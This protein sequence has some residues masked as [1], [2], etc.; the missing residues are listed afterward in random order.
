[1][2]PLLF[3]PLLFCACLP[4]GTGNPLQDAA[5]GLDSSAASDAGGGFDASATDAGAASDTG[6]QIPDSG[7]GSDASV[8]DAGGDA[9]CSDAGPPGCGVTGGPSCECLAGDEL[10]LGNGVPL[11]MADHPAVDDRFTLIRQRGEPEGE[12]LEAL[13]V[14]TDDGSTESTFVLATQVDHAAA[15]AGDSISITYVPDSAD[16]ELRLLDAPIMM[17]AGEPTEQSFVHT[18]PIG[19]LAVARAGATSVTAFVSATSDEPS[20]GQ[21]VFV[22][23]VVDGVADPGASQHGG[24]AE[25]RAIAITAAPEGWVLAYAT[26]DAVFTQL[27]DASGVAV[28]SAQ[29]I[30]SASFVS[31]LQLVARDEGFVLALDGSTP[32]VHFLDVEAAP[33]SHASVAGRIVALEWASTGHV[34]TVRSDAVTCSSSASRLIFERTTTDGMSLHEPVQVGLGDSA[35]IVL[36]NG[37]PWVSSVAGSDLSIVNACIADD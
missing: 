37:V 24:D 3:L 8:S 36:L 4:T 26:N 29:E 18:H 16:S 19:E 34:M 14:A 22:H 11:A 32:A 31:A 17:G 35:S 6:P 20:D 13:V 1:M 21:S 12:V 9:S 23:R 25:L 33:V 5:P 7:P 15:V 28:G 27:L 10:F 2:R 30:T